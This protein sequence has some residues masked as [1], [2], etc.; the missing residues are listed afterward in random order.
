MR[1]PSFMIFRT[2]SPPQ[3]RGIRI[4]LLLLCVLI[5]SG[6]SVS[7]ADEKDEKD[8]EAPTFNLLAE[9]NRPLVSVCA[10]SA[11]RLLEKAEFLF[12]TAG[13]PAAT[14]R[15]EDFVSETLND[16][17]GFDRSKP[18]GV[19]LYLPVAF[20]PIPEF[21]GVVPIESV[22]QATKLI[23]KAP[24]LIKKG[25]EEG[26]YEII[27]PRQT[28]P[29]LMRNGY[30][31][32]P[33]G[34]N[35]SETILDREF[36]DPA[37]LFAKQAAEFDVA[38]NLDV[39]SI[40]PGT[41][42]L[43]G[44][45]I[46][47]GISTQMQQRD[48][49]PEGVYRIRRAEGDRTI[50]AFQQLLN[51]CQNITLGLAV[52]PDDHSADIEM[53]FNA[54]AGTKLFEEIF[55]SVS[56][57]SYFIPL[58][59]EEAPVSLSI[60]S[61]I[62]ERDRNA[63]IEMMDGLELEIARQIELNSLGSVPTTDGPIG[64]ALDAMQ[65][66]LDE[67]HLDAFAQLYNDPDGKLVVVWAMRVRDGEDIG[68]GVQDVLSRL[69]S[70][71]NLRRIGELQ[72]GYGEHLGVTFHRI[73]FRDQSPGAVEL[74]GQGVGLTVGVSARAIWGCLGGENSYSQLTGVMDQL[75][76]ALQQPQERTPPPNFRIIINVNKLVEMQQKVGAASRQAAVEAEAAT[77]EAVAV[78]AVAAD[79]AQ[80][81]QP[82]NPTRSRR[83]QRRERGG[84][85]FREAM[86]EGDDRVEIAFRPTETGG[87][88]QVHLEEGFIRFFG[89]LIGTGI[90]GNQDEEE[91][92]PQARPVEVQ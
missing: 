36:P 55:E 66:T 31:F 2:P 19:M 78:E 74:F 64:L 8:D 35:T 40:P 72:L 26:R 34:N 81:P 75:E 83:A 53:V 68:L 25:S 59:D 5:L 85:F 51:E 61:V 10:A 87:R 30:A 86:A 21:I 56:R 41:R 3:N 79:G 80:P 17:E 4:R 46:Q 92:A 11:D 6:S 44:T 65:T 9:G 88:M 49:E 12:E 47:S 90:T 29:I 7:R 70:S 48:G 62:N 63:Y 24:V 76:A 18:F 54:L 60:S 33:I 23:E 20:P 16:L 57:P 14:Q 67:G 42:T 45:M 50:A 82:P 89:R 27:G 91:S 37:S 15:L 73:T 1:I 69:Q 43:L 28:T 38:L 77:T 84:Q 52:N 58:L 39:E 22:E 32:F 71:E 13:M